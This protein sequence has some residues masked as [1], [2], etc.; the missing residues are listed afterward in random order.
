[1]P[2]VQFNACLLLHHGQYACHVCVTMTEA[3]VPDIKVP[4]T[5]MMLQT[6]M[7]QLD[8]T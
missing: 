6:S 4:H 8:M 3:S 2:P 1:M 7:L 5:H